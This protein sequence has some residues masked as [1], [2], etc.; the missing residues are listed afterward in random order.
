MSWN[1]H[2]YCLLAFCL[3]LTALVELGISEAPVGHASAA[4]HAAVVVRTQ[5]VAVTSEWPQ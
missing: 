3:A 5:T 4:R 2:C 1:L